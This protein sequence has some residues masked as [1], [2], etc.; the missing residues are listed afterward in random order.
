MAFF[1]L[2]YVMPA[3]MFCCVRALLYVYIIIY[4]I[5]NTYKKGGEMQQRDA[6]GQYSVITQR[7]DTVKIMWRIDVD[8]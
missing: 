1:F 7:K 5:Y 6:A 4:S 8:G 2:F 3:Q